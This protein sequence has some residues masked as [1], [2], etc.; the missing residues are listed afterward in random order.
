MPEPM[1]QYLQQLEELLQTEQATEHS[2]RAAL[3]MLVKQHR[4]DVTT[5]NEAKRIACGAPDLTIQVNQLTIGYIEAKDMGKSLAEAADSDQLTRYR[6]ALDNLI[7]TDY[8]EFRWY[9]G[10]ELRLTA[11]LG[12]VEK[13]KPRG[14]RLRRELNVNPVTQLLQGFLSHSPEQIASAVEIAHRMA[15]LTHLIRDIMVGTFE[16]NQAS[17]MT[18]GLR[19]ALAQTLLPELNQPEHFKDF[20]DIYAQTIAYGLFAARCQHR[21]AAMFRLAD[22][23]NDIPKTNPF[24]RLLFA[25]ISNLQFEDEPYI[26]FVHDLVQLLAQADMNAILADFGRTASQE[27]PIVHFYETFL[28]AYDPHLREL[29]GVYYTPKPVVAYLVRSVDELLR[30]HF[31]LPDGLADTTTVEQ[32]G[33]TLPRMLLLDPA[34]GTGT[35]LYGVIEFIRQQFQRQGNV[36]MWSAYVRDHLLKRLCGFELLMVPYAVAHLKLAWQLA[37]LDLEESIR[38]PWV[39]DFANNERLKIYLTNT[40]EEPITH[41]PELFWLRIITEE[42]QAAARI[43]QEWPILVVMGNPPYAGHSANS[44]WKRNNEGKL[45]RNFIGK[46]L[47][48]YYQVDGQPLGERNSKWLQD[49]Y[50][51]FIRWGQWR[52]EQTGGGILAFI[53][54]HGYL[55]NPTFRGMRQSLLKTFD[56]IYLLDLHGN[57]KKKERTLDGGKDEN[58][59][60]IQQGVAIAIFVKFPH[61]SSEVLA[62]IYHADL[63]GRRADKYEWLESHALNDTPWQE[64]K[65]QSPFYLFIPQNVDLLPEY[66]KG[67]RITEIMPFNNTGVITSRDKFVIDFEKIALSQRIKEFATSKLDNMREKYNLQD[68]REKTLAESREMVQNMKNPDEHIIK[69]LYRPFDYRW[70]F[71]SNALVRWPVYDTMQHTLKGQN[72]GLIYMRQ[73]AL[74]DKYTHFGVSTMPVD[75]RAFY[76]NKGV[77]SF[78]PL[79]L[80]QNGQLFNTLPWPADE[81]GRVPNLHPDF[82]ADLEKRLGLKFEPYQ[83]CEVLKTSQVFTTED[84]FHYIYAIFHS[85]T[86]RQRYAEFLKIDFPRVPLTN[87]RDLFWQLAGLGR[88]LVALHLL[89]QLPPLTTQYPITGDNEV[90]KGY[91]TY[92]NKRIYL[93][94][95]QYF[96]E[97]EPTI[98][99]FQLGGY[100]ILDKWLKNRR[101]RKLNYDELQHY[102]KIIAALQE[103]ERLMAEVDALVPAWPL[104]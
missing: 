62:K 23:A 93:N 47:Q 86:Y 53:T 70:L 87:D 7:L 6:Q 21:S 74:Q 31:N 54:N 1:K 80:Y 96:A 72:I 43:K 84:I 16:Q 61:Q 18:N 68:V 38:A 45:V 37:G 13:L 5:I 94:K 66:K 73:V 97:V 55:D 34:V 101:G 3:E 79:Y 100:Q 52:I 28:T 24:L 89:N 95:K 10:G 9:V 46:L 14:Y 64:L 33:Q 26:G 50:V 51:K 75:N 103:T 36:G 2:Y 30:T 27:D 29:R 19:E 35:F 63:R 82:V 92:Q 88:Q 39:Y 15:Q 99:Q 65:P 11:T 91:P 69:F 12:Q 85:P 60:D 98:W 77:M 40:L 90:A 42:A 78:A 20:A 76:S 17:E 58:I 49:D 44:S 59:F 4:P 48:D 83:T 57:V 67:W 8:L 32:N 25:N 71:Y 56:R 81:H 104:K 102:Q 22:A 41:M